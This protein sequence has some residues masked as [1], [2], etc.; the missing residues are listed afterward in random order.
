MSIHRFALAGLL[1]GSVSASSSVSSPASSRVHVPSVTCRTVIGTTSVASVSTTTLT[2]TLHDR[3]PIVTFTT[4]Q[5]TVTET[6]ATFT[7]SLMDYKT[8][9]V[10]VTEDTF[11]TATVTV[12]GDVVTATIYITVSTTST[13][14]STI[15]TS[16][17][18]TPI[19]D[20]IPTPFASR[21]SLLDEDDCSE[22]PWIDDYQY[23]L[24]V[25]CHEKII[26]K[27]TSTSTVTGVPITT[28]VATP[29]TTATEISTISTTSF[30]VPGDLSTT[31]SYST[32]STLTMTTYVPG[33]TTTVTSTTTA[34]AAVATA[35]VVDSCAANNI[36]GAPVSSEFGSFAGQYIN[37]INFITVPGYKV[38]TA[39]SDSAYD[40]CVSCIETSGCAFSWF[41]DESSQSYCYLVMTTTCSTTST[42]GTAGF[43]SNPNNWQ[44]SN[45][46]CGYVKGIDFSFI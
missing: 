4:T 2:R 44:L 8:T 36:A 41:V 37:E 21:R 7:L 39:S 43:N 32:T 35:T 40:C 22:G 33:E 23:P 6:P 5:D 45:G 1:L 29:I 14:T 24:E 42:Y 11:D 17:G 28:T 13:T 30:V 19:A 12:P 20:T 25:E 34:L 27:T 3:L 18:F 38:T 31:L 15:A 46:N 16:D 10:T 26:F 9:T